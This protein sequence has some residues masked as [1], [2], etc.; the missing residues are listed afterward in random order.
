MAFSVYRGW[1]TLLIG[2]ENSISFLYIYFYCRLSFAG[3]FSEN[4][5]STIKADGAGTAPE[6]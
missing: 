3:L 2:S 5:H 4:R 1:E 6:T